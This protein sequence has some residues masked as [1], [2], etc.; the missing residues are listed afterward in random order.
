MD[1]ERTE[2]TTMNND[3]VID[4]D[5]LDKGGTLPVKVI[6][7]LGAL[8][9]GGA[10]CLKNKIFGKKYAVVEHGVAKKIK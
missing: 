8:L 7:G 2:L 3:D 4:T 6:F 1:E 9:L 5:D 10:I